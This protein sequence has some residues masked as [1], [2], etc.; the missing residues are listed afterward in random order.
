MK[1]QFVIIVLLSLL[2]CK[3]NSEN[4]EKKQSSQIVDT[5]SFKRDIES[6]INRKDVNKKKKSDTIENKIDKRFL[7]KYGIGVETDG[8]NQGTAIINYE[9]EIFEEFVILRLETIHEPVICDG[10]YDF[11]MKG[12]VLQLFYA[13]SDEPCTRDSPMFEIKSENNKLFVL[14]L[15]GEGTNKSWIEI[16][17]IK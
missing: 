7:G 14:G 4:E 8:L 12:D 10:M 13:D 2:G 5:L 9:F 6:N 1:I 15:G 17:E 16:Y 3:G 11:K